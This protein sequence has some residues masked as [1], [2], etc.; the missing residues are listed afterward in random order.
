MVAP[1][2]YIWEMSTRATLHA[3]PLGV[4]EQLE[5]P[6]ISARLSAEDYSPAFQVC[7]PYRGAFVWHVAHDA[8]VSDANTVLFVRSG[9][10]YR[11]SQ[12]VYEGYG[13]IIVT[14]A[15]RLLEEVLQTDV[16]SLGR[17]E[18]FTQRRRVTSV[19]LLRARSNWL[20][21]SARGALDGLEADEAMVSLLRL[22]FDATP[23]SVGGGSAAR[24]VNQTKEYLATHME[25]SPQLSEIAREVGA[26][27]AH[28]TTVFRRSEGMPVHRYLA[29]LR[30]SRAL[31]ALPDADDLTN[32]ALDLGF[33]SHSHFTFAFRRAFGC[34]PSSFRAEAGR[35]RP[36]ATRD[37]RLET[38]TS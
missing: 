11:I 19:A 36:F 37:R 22:A 32:L 10:P 6:G 26:S 21:V 7:L 3:G 29:Q 28:L 8:V 16:A 34:T 13:E 24:L 23:A 5:S 9:E 12:A 17:H 31:V 27:P 30:L 38:L 33:A 25:R 15:P 14:P 4:A 2:A 35:N 18:A 20:R 1:V